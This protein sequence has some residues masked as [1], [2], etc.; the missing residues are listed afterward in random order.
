M[1]SES[2]LGSQL[3]YGL[4]DKPPFSRAVVLA[5]QHVLTMFGSTMARWVPN[6][7]RSDSTIC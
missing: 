1:A 2:T 7:L 6:V 4:N 3:I 5:A